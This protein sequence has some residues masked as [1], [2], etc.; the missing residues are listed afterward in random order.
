MNLYQKIVKIMGEVKS[1]KK[2]GKVNFKQTRYNFLSE[3]KTTATLREKFVENNIMIY[4]ISAQ[5]TI[6]GKVTHGHYTF[7]MV[8]A[9]NPEEFIDI[10]STGQGQDSSDKGSGKA[11]S[12]AFKYALWRAFAIPSNDDPDQIS[13]AQHEAEEA[14][15]RKTEAAIIDNAKFQ[16]L[17]L[18]LDETET[19]KIKFCAYFKVNSIKEMTNKQW[20]KA[21]DM[22]TKKREN[23]Q[24]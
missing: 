8:N 11:Q 24:G 16:S 13:S 6:S 20:M 1:L 12:Y 21:M 3:A 2:D 18:M 23:P 14:E 17:E 19:D 7:R 10:Q 15:R 22:L 4:P 5:E 9:D